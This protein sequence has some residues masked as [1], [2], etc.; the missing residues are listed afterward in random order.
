MKEFTFLVTCMLVF[1]HSEDILCR[2]TYDDTEENPFLSGIDRTIGVFNISG[3]ADFSKEVAEKGLGEPKIHL[4]FTLD[5]SGVI[6]VTK[7]EASVDLPPPPEEPSDENIT[8]DVT[9]EGDEKDAGEVETESATVNNEDSESTVE[10]ESSSENDAKSEPETGSDSENNT[11]TEDSKKKKSRKEKRKEKKAKKEKAETQIKRTLVVEQDFSATVP[12]IMTKSRLQA[13][14][15]KLMR[16]K[17]AD[18]ARKAKETA[19]NELETYVYA[20][21]NRLRDEDGKDQLGG[22]STEEQ[23]EE[24]INKCNEVEDWL[25]D[26]GRNADLSE[27]KTKESEIQVPADKIFKRFKESIDR[28]KAV[29]RALRQL[30]NVTKKIDSWS[31]KMPHITDEEIAKLRDLIS[32]VEGWISNKVEAQETADPTEDPVF[33]AS[34]GNAIGD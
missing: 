2:L 1:K 25:Y 29:K 20:V 6:S 23:R 7:A 8:S 27:F 4:S 10:P 18:E 31:T 34:E 26:E 16:L 24:I 11:K 14:R 30:Q 33:L 13:S 32:E 9:N 17:K 15:Q 3:I 22:V 28:P 12:P 5:A 19:L 21:R